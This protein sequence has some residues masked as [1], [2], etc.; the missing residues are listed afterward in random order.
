M[1]SL[2]GHSWPWW[3][4]SS[5]EISDFY[6]IGYGGQYVTMFPALDLVTVMTG[7]VSNHPNHR[8]VISELAS[9]VSAS[10]PARLS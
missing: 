4:P 9:H 6:A 8:H 3:L 2:P 5:N 7:E 10:E 1:D